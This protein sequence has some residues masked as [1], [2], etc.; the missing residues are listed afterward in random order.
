MRDQATVQTFVL[1]K[2]DK[3]SS[4]FMDHMHSSHSFDLLM[5]PFVRLQLMFE[6]RPRMIQNPTR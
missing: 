1:F 5:G 6:R 2:T 4:R 3:S